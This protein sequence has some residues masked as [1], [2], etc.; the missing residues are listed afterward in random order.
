MTIA[1]GT[2]AAWSPKADQVAFADPRCGERQGIYVVR[3]DGAD[4]RRLSRHCTIY[5]TELRERIVG[6]PADDTIY[7]RDRKR[8]RVDC[9]EGTDLVVADSV[10]LLR[11]C[12]AIHR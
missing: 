6:T 7:A 10:D 11:N 9:G 1:H 4:M 5:G 8:D 2:D 12:E 3:A